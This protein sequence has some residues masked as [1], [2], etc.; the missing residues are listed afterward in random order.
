MSAS[1]EI[2]REQLFGD[3]LSCEEIHPDAF[4]P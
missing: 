2:A 3:V 4:V 1:V